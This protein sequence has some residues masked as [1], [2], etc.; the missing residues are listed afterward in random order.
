MEPPDSKH[1]AAPPTAAPPL[2]SLRDP[3]DLAVPPPDPTPNMTACTPGRDSF[4]AVKP[5]LPWRAT[6][7]DLT[8]ILFFFLIL[9]KRAFGHVWAIFSS[10]SE[11]VTYLDFNH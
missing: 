6:M 8:F 5:N 1:A 10:V 9:A 3:D 4:L 2:G 7:E 11:T